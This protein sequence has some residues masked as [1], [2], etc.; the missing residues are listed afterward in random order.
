MLKRPMDVALRHFDLLYRTFCLRSW[1]SKDNESTC[2][3]QY[4]QLLYCLR[5]C[6]G[7]FFG[8]SSNSPDLIEFMM[9]L[10][11]LQDKE[12]LLY[13]FKLCCLSITSPS[14]AFADVIIGSIS[15]AG[16]QSRFTDVVLPCQNYMAQVSGYVTLCSNDA[17]LENFTLVSSSFGRAAF[18]STYD[19]WVYADSFERSK[20]YKS[21]Q[22]S[23]RSV[24]TGPKKASPD[25]RRMI[26]LWM[27]QP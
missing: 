18:S 20:I 14:P 27:S 8:V 15:T 6:Y 1:V 11:F 26:L 9:G 21:L 7:S 17:N 16:H 3:D 12:H 2:R 25:V 13:L 4:T 24:L 22:S 10:D 5:I 19:P 23:Y